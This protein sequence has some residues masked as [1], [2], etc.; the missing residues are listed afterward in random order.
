MQAR[1]KRTEK[2]L[3][4]YEQKCAKLED[5]LQ[6]KERE[7]GDFE[8]STNNDKREYESKI[9]NLEHTLANLDKDN[10]KLN[11]IASDQEKDFKNLAKSEKELHK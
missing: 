7:L 4:I 6:K 5:D 1:H 2:K 8:F 10:R 11:K 9:A 3:E